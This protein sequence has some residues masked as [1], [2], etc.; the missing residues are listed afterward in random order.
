MEFIVKSAVNDVKNAFLQMNESNR[1]AMEKLTAEI[2]AKG[3]AG[4]EEDRLELQ[5]LRDKTLYE[6]MDTLVNTA[7]IGLEAQIKQSKAKNDQ[8]S[9]GGDVDGMIFKTIQ[10]LQQ[11]VSE[12]RDATASM[13]EEEAQ[14]RMA[15]TEQV[16]NT[17]ISRFNTVE[18]QVQESQMKIQQIGQS[19]LNINAIQANNSGNIDTSNLQQRVTV[20]EEQVQ[21]TNAMVQ[22][23]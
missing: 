15:D 7:K 17:F 6:Y 20:V 19:D 14:Q 13:I 23:L 2:E 1:K 5:K 21:E 12:L 4:D 22:R 16:K 8:A 18:R 10:A 11:S 9:G 3:F